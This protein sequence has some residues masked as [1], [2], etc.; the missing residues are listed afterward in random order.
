M[1]EAVL[2]LLKWRAIVEVLILWFVIYRI[3]LFLKGTRAVYL[4]RGI[5]IL[6]ISFFIFQW[7][8][9]YILSWLLTKFFAFFLILVVIIFQPELREG[10]IRLGKR[11]FFPLELRT[12]EIEKTI[13][14]IVTAVSNMS[15]KKIGALIAIKKEIGL[16]DF[17]ETGVIL[18]AQISA[19]LL[20]N[21][22]YP[23]SPLHDGGVIIDGA[24]IAS[25]SCLFPITDNPNLEKTLGMRHRAAVGLSEASD[26]VVIVVSEES[27][28]ISL[29][30]NGQLT[31]NLSCE[32]LLTILKGQLRREK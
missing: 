24:V 15:K 25:A 23:N 13:K 21:I 11:H 32:E 16:K 2:G 29:A 17:I 28:A 31:R 10:L 18:N 19:F 4:L 12:E 27:G 7:L 30:I 1:K 20:E 22:F 14:E 9:F 5:V 8:G 26:A 6:L 3:F